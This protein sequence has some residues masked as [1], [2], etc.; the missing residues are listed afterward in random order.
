[1]IVNKL[2]KYKMINNLFKILQKEMNTCNNY[3]KMKQK[4]K[5][6]KIF[7][8]KKIKII[9]HSNKNN[10]IYKIKIRILNLYIQ[11]KI[12]CNFYILEMKLLNKKFKILKKSKKK[13]I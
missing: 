13:T 9:K 8:Y 11:Y 6:S 2:T 3:Y 1:M 5:I 4:I 12:K 7:K 10:L